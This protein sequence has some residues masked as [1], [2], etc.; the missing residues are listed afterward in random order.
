VA[1]SRTD[2]ARGVTHHITCHSTCGQEW[3]IASSRHLAAGSDFS[4]GANH[5]MSCEHPGIIVRKD[6]RDGPPEGDTVLAAIWTRI[7]PSTF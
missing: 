3:I 2:A 1:A 6:G 5:M 4:M 7:H